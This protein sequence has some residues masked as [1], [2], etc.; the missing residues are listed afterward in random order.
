MGE[1][2]A[3][4]PL[5][6]SSLPLKTSWLRRLGLKLGSCWSLLGPPWGSRKG[7]A[8]GVLRRQDSPQP[9]PLAVPESSL[10]G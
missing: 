9:L 7:A 2:R 6:S 10:S 1:S 4:R 8:D 3:A 5:D